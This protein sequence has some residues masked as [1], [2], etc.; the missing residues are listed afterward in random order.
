VTTT[1]LTAASPASAESIF[2]PRHRTTSGGVLVLVTLIAFEA[3][4][5]A[6][7]LPTAAREVHGIGAIGW[8]FTGFLVTNVVGMVVSGQLCDQHGP[9]P[10]LLAGLLA[11]ATGL[12]VAGTAGTMVQLVVGRCI[13][14]LGSGLL[15]T[16]IYVVLGE[17]YPD[18]LRPK[19]FAAMSSAW[20][21]PALV[22]PLVSGTLAQHASWRWVFLGLLPFVFVGSALMIPAL[23]TLGARDRAAAP[24]TRLADPRRVLCAV[25]VA[26]GIGALEAAGQHPSVPM[27]GVAV[28]GLAALASGLR[29]LLPAGTI[30]VRRGVSAPVAL[31]GL[32]AGAFF[33]VESMVPLSMNVQHGYGA[34][35]AG[36]PL[37]LSG[38]TWSLGSWWQGRDKYSASDRSGLIRAGFGFVA[39]AA[40]L[41]AIASVPAVPGWLMYPAWGSAGIGA[42]LTMSSVAVLLLRYTNDADRGAD[43]AALQLSDAVVSAITT[44]FAGVLVAAAARGAI[45][46]TAAFT[47]LDLTMCAVALIGVAVAGQ[48]RAPQAKVSAVKG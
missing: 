34:T 5:V 29:R 44:G 31:R 26:G 7:A 27:V 17:T 36:L 11:F 12:L 16:A 43:S 2:G 46:Y 9:R 40:A 15:I 13:Q 42:G 1:P 20:V 38:V 18:E 10:A 47:V 45:G 37:V 19:I 30:R 23:R 14:G 4:A 33:G 48:A 24:P 41:T 21:V 28:V 3:M 35:A 6:A 22:G 32:L 39:L 8:A 25:A